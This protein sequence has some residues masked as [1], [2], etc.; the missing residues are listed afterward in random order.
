MNTALPMLDKNHDDVIISPR[1]QGAGQIKVDKAIENTTSLTDST[2]GDGALALK[3][4]EQNTRFSVTLQNNGSKAAT[5]QFTDFGGV[6][7][8]AQ[9][10]TAEVYETKIN[11]A[12]LT[13]SKNSVTLKP[14]E[15]QTIQLQLDLPS[16]FAKQQFVEGYIGFTSDTQPSLT[17]PFVG[18]YGDYSLAPVIDAPIYDQASIQGFGYFT[19]KNNT[20]LGLKNNTIDPEL[21]AISPNKDGRK[22]EAK[23]TF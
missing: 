2:D 3:Q 1:R 17:I 4:I 15:T 11:D 18:F 20:F 5:Y 23:P 13:T 22:D 14:G 19:D 21:V 10:S 12:K 16:S 9:T 7:T 8:E 6:Y